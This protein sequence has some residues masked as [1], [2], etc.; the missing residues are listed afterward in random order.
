MP[1]FLALFLIAALSSSCGTSP[2]RAEYATQA[3]EL[4][5]FEFFDGPVTGWAIV[6]NRKGQVLQ[7]FKV[8]IEGSVEGETLTLD[9]TFSYFLGEG[10][11]KR[12][13]VIDKNSPNERDF[14]GRADDIIDLGQGVAYGNALN[15]QYQMDLTVSSGTYRVSFNDWMWA[16]DESSLINRAYIKKFGLVLAEVTIFMKQGRY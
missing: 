8:A 14:T 10:V 3:P 6:Q 11:E 9:E 2:Y 16:I 7:R 5:L 13:W 1:R 15:W 12:I 4:D